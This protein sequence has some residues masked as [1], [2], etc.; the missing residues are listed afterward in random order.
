MKKVK[1]DYEKTVH[2]NTMIIIDE[3]SKSIQENS[4]VKY[5]IQTNG[6]IMSIIFDA[7]NY[8]CDTFPEY[9]YF[10][11]AKA[12]K[13]S[14]ARLNENVLVIDPYQDYRINMIYL[15]DADENIIEEIEIIEDSVGIYL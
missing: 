15:V 3:I 11:K 1:I 9:D 4:D 14:V 12:K 13:Y 10:N 5:T 7:L 2:E 6:N 8:Q